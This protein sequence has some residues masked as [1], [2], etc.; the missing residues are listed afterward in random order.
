MKAHLLALA[1]LW[2]GAALPARP[3]TGGAGEEA[4]PITL[5]V[6]GAYSGWGIPDPN[7]SAPFE[8]AKRAVFEAFTRKFPH[9]R[10]QRFTALNIQGPAAESGIL[11]AFAGGAAPDIVYVNMRLMRQYIG[12]GFLQPLD[13]LIAQRPE[14]LARVHPNLRKELD[15]EGHIWSVPSA[16]FVQALYYRKDL[17]REAGLNPNRPPQTWDEFYAYCQKLYDPSKGRWG[18]VFP[19]SDMSWYW[20]NFLYSAGGDVTK[21]LPDGR[22]AAAF[23]TDAGEAALGFYRKLLTGAWTDPRTGKRVQGVCIKSSTQ[24]QD[25]SAG[26]VAMWFAYQSDDITNMNSYDLNPSLL[27]IAAMPRGPTG[28]QSNELNASMWGINA[29]VRDPQKRA[30]CYE[31][32]RFMGSDEASRIRVQAFVDNGLGQLVNPVELQRWGYDEYITASQRP[33]LE[34]QKTLFDN[35]KPEPAGP[36]MA[37]IYNLLDEPL[38]QSTL[39]PDR[40]LQKILADAAFKVNS[41]LLNYTTPAER[42]RNRLIALA[43]AL[44]LLAALLA[45]AARAVLEAWRMRGE[46][47]PGARLPL[48]TH[49]SAWAFMAPAIASIAVWAYLPLL[50]GMLMAFQDYRILGGG[51]WVGL[52]N[53]IEAA[54]QETFRQ[55]MVNAFVFTAWLLGLGFVLPIVLALLLHEAPRGKVLFRFL[56]YLPAVTT[57]I[58]VAMLWKQFWEPGEQGFANTLL[59]LFHVAPQK[60]LEDPALAKFAVVVPLVWAGAGPGSIIYLAALQSIP[61]EMYEAADLDGAGFFTKIWRVTLPTLGPLIVINLVGATIGAFKIME[62][63]L[64]QT[65]GGPDNA[66]YTIGLEVWYNAFMY[67]KF[68]YATAAAW[69]MGTLLIGLTLY[70]LRMLQ[71]LRFAAGGR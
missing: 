56:Y 10:L 15:V 3:Q 43:I 16:Q 17:F 1:L 68:G 49:L 47:A 55:G 8:R 53:F 20:I 70:Q 69:M 59:A 36:N 19:P 24:R 51:K 64:V 65:G 40:P 2:C 71:S 25:I 46:A 39:Y 66:T 9:I 41:K 54:S 62:P 35:G 11:M 50:R 23:D 32:L 13:D 27:G 5:T 29:T 4:A 6:G 60:W 12:Q 52:D 44:V 22:Y 42:A 58:V 21:R 30:A 61:D 33:W 7:A 45:L 26:K 31:F 38:D 67:L 14:T 63:V 57:S 48:R 37:F 28:L 18:F 34:A